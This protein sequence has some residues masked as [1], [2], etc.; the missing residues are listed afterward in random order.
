[1]IAITDSS[2]PG[3]DFISRQWVCE[4]LLRG[5]GKQMGGGGVPSSAGRR[6]ACWG[7]GSSPPPRLGSGCSQQLGT[8]LADRGPAALQK[9]LAFCSPGGQ[10]SARSSRLPEGCG[11]GC[12]RRWGSGCDGAAMDQRWHR[13]LFSS[14]SPLLHGSRQSRSRH[15]TQHPHGV[16]GRGCSSSKPRPHTRCHR[17]SH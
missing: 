13:G 15:R 3:S 16:D 10:C 7:G 14:L 1:M 8:A 6:L 4:Q 5:A 9:A 2:S 11:A 17:H 12:C